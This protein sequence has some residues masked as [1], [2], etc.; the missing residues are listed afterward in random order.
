[1][2]SIRSKL[3]I[4]CL[5]VTTAIFLC[6]F[7]LQAN[8]Y[9]ELNN[10]VQ[11]INNR[12][13]VKI[14]ALL[15]NTSRQNLEKTRE[16][17]HK[18]LTRKGY[19]LLKKDQLVLRPL[20]EDYAA[21]AVK[22]YLKRVYDL[23]NDIRLAAFI[24]EREGRIRAWEYIS[25]EHPETVGYQTFWDPAEK[26]WISREG[27]KTTRINDDAVAE[28]LKTRDISVR[29]STL[30]TRDEDG[31]LRI[32][33]TLDC[34]IPIMAGTERGGEAERAWLRYVLTLE[35]MEL[36]L[37]MEKVRQKETL[38]AWLQ[39]A[40]ANNRE[41]LSA[42]RAKAA[43][44]NRVIFG[45]LLLLGTL[46]LGL[47]WFTAHHLTRPLKRLVRAAEEISTG[48]YSNEI[49]ST[50]QDEIGVLAGTMDHMRTQVLDSRKNLEKT[51]G[52]RT[53]ELREAHRALD[54]ERAKSLYA[55]RLA[56]VGEMA[57]G[58]AHEVNNP[59]AIINLL[60]S[61]IA[62]FAGPKGIDHPDILQDTKKMHL[63][64]KRIRDITDS[65][66]TFSKD[67]VRERQDDDKETFPL[68][69]V[70]DQVMEICE[71]R[72]RGKRIRLLTKDNLTGSGIMVHGH[73]SRLVQV[74]IN[75]IQNSIEAVSDSEDPWIRLDFSQQGA[76]V[77]ISVSDSGP[78]IPPENRG[79]IMEPFFTTKPIGQGTGLGLSIS[80]GII[81]SH[82]GRI[83]LDRNADATTF[84]V[85]LPV[86]DTLHQA[87]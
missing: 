8:S 47:F 72:L 60:A 35:N 34:T 31:R 62:R 87:S 68:F 21:G 27:E 36:A 82:G 24:T 53:R 38:R 70:L 10:A 41:L 56:A 50:S 39:E 77:R 2:K 81:Q 13:S 69:S 1:M 48:C 18:A 66:L 85:T 86:A 14:E 65:L 9:F 74:L 42:I 12:F 22:D 78:G 23:D 16:R 67:A 83:E 46:A 54:E 20:W 61:R 51:V 19:N 40:G 5:V 32:V 26:A 4:T 58:V 11:G 49:K 28:I 7:L 64:I 52:E 71:G 80:S 3:I 29:E 44:G 59:L 25:D 30:K 15:V 75:L 37:A 76:Q 79:K 17:H 57:A 33:K 73:K 6:F 84:V 63:T 43:E 45:L 55:S